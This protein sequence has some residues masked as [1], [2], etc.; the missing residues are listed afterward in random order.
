[1]VVIDI[2]LVAY[3][4]WLTLRASTKLYRLLGED[5][6]SAISRIMG[7]MLI[8]IGGQFVINGIGNLLHDPAFW[9]LAK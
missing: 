3:I 8:C 9:P 2:L 1:M 5:G 7:F 6:I 4:S